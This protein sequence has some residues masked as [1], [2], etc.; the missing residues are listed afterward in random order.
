MRIRSIL[1]AGA[2]S[3]ATVTPV[4]ATEAFVG[5]WAITSSACTGTGTTPATAP[6]NATET[7][8]RWFGDPCRIHKMYKIGTAVYVQARCF[9]DRTTETPITLDARGDRM[10]VAWNGAKSQELHRCK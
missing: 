4:V 3:A 9:G 8:V 5:R 10:L 2:I 6:L 7:A 1:L